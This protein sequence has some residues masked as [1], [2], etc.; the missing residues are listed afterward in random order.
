MFG[1]LNDYL[2]FFF[3]VIDCIEELS[4]VLN[5]IWVN[6]EEVNCLVVLCEE[7]LELLDKKIYDLVDVVVLME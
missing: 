3:V 2:E 4:V 5:K 1:L 7:D 6:M